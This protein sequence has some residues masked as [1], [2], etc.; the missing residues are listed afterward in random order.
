MGK[1]MKSTKQLNNYQI[2]SQVKLYVLQK[3]YTQDIGCYLCLTM[4]PVIQFL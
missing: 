4:Q 2:K 3:Y 1:Q